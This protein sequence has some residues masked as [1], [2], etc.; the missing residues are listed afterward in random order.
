MN[1]DGSNVGDGEDEET[2]GEP[3]DPIIPPNEIT[4]IY[5]DW[6]GTVFGDVGGQDKITK[7]N[8][9]ITE[10]E[11]NTNKSFGKKF[12]QPRKNLVWF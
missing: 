9:E 11:D 7:D 5:S 3:T 1:G 6:S 10:N 12:R 2:P 8:F 4:T